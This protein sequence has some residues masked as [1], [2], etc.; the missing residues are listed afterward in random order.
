MAALEALFVGG[1]KVRRVSGPPVDDNAGLLEQ[2]LAMAHA[3]FSSEE[4]GAWDLM[5]A[6]DLPDVLERTALG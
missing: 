2:A 3:H 6:G 1:L 4:A 5:V